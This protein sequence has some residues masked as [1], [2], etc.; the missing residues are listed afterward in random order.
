ML[1]G[2]QVPRDWS[3]CEGGGA[4]W[5]SGAGH[6]APGKAEARCLRAGWGRGRLGV[7]CEEL[8]TLVEQGLW[9]WDSA[10]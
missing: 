2:R 6:G 3:P 8:A 4:G 9:L 1:E 5:T 7:G 10:A